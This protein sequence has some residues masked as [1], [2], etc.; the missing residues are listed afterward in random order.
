MQIQVCRK[1]IIEPKF[2]TNRSA[3][4]KSD[5]SICLVFAMYVYKLQKW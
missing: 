2:C 5:V 3:G 4:T 1:Q